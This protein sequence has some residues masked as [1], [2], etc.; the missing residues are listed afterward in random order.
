MSGWYLQL[1]QTPSGHLFLAWRCG[2][3]A[4]LISLRPRAC[5]WDYHLATDRLDELVQYPFS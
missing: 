4:A 2:Q 3:V 5:A 1:Q